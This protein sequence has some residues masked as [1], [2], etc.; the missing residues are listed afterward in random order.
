[1]ISAHGSMRHVTTLLLAFASATAAMRLARR[2][3]LATGGAALGLGAPHVGKISAAG[4]VSYT[5]AEFGVSYSV[6]VGFSTSASDMSG[7]RSLV[8]AAD[9][10]DADFNVFCAF[11][12]VQADYTGLGSFGTLDSVATTVLPQCAISGGGRCTLA[13]DGIE[14]TMLSAATVRNNYEFDYRIDQQ[15]AGSLTTRHLRSLWSIKT[16]EG[17]GKW[18]VTLTVQCL[19]PR[20]AELAPT[21]RE[22]IASFK[23][24]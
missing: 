3:A 15:V 23:Y 2:A 21:M 9:P 18:L 12:P 17:R 19:E 22:I 10:K 24:T 16:E 20:Y 14:G 5:N 7:S 1:V 4:L 13:A 8:V 6:P 11:T